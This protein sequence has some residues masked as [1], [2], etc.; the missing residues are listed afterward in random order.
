DRR[1]VRQHLAAVDALPA[2]RVRLGLVES[3][4]RELL[5]QEAR[6]SGEAHEL[7]KL[8]AVAERVRRPELAAANAE[9]LLEEPL[10]VHELAEQRLARRQIAVRL[11]PAAADGNELAGRDLRANALPQVGLALLD[12]RV[13]LGLRARK[14]KV[15]VLVHVPRLAGERAHELSLGL[16][17][18]PEP[19]RVDV[20]VTDCID[21][22]H[23]RAVV[24][25]VQR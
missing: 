22:V 2:E 8:P 21:L 17:E 16:G 18:R 24:M 7:G 1:V 6:D 10:A 5:R 15:L 14:A 13:L 25:L 19:R 23:A 9:L 4:P 20:R 12:P 3:V 11:N